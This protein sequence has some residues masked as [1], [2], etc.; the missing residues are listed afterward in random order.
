MN[1]LLIKEIR[2]GSSKLSWLFIAFGLM[3][4]IP[5]YPILCGAFFITFG[6][7]QSF[8]YARE[9]NDIVYSALLPVAKK[10]VVRGKY[11]FAMMIEGCGFM[12]M[13]ALTIV[14][15]T[16]LSEAPIYRNNVLMNANPFYLG[17]VLVI[18]ALFNSV[19][20]G[21]FFKTAHKFT[22]PF[23][24]YLISV[25]VVIGISETLH[26]IPGLSALNA[27]GFEHFGLQSGTLAAG[28]VIYTLLT[29]LSCR[30][31]MSSFEK[32]DL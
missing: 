27:F 2:L 11:A 9:A 20:I 7:F 5:G 8:Q 13:T 30:R 6:L 21:G 28:T 24:L 31:S 23:V 32:I 29:C 17:M 18:F 22:K 16:V 1:N 14:R 25:I 15:M 4:M 12:L 3:A 26:H 19:F 10:D